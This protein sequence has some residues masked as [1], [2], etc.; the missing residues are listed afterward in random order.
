MKYTGLNL[1]T[2]I[3]ISVIAILSFS[4][5]LLSTDFKLI[6]KFFSLLLFLLP[7]LVYQIINWSDRFN[8][9][10]RDLYPWAFLMGFGILSN[11]ALIIN[12]IINSLTGEL[13]LIAIGA[14][15]NEEI[16][17]LLTVY[18]IIKFGYRGAYTKLGLIALGALVGTGFALTE[19]LYYTIS[20]NEPFYMVA[21]RM[22]FAPFFHATTGAIYALVLFK[23][24]KREYIFLALIFL[25][26]FHM[27]WNI[28]ALINSSVSFITLL[29]LLVTAVFISLF[30]FERERYAGLL[31]LSY[32]NELDLELFNESNGGNLSEI[33]EIRNYK[34]YI[35]SI[36]EDNLASNNSDKAN[37]LVEVTEPPL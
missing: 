24:K 25:I 20:S 16:L 32:L 23:S 28:S 37:E 11:S 36:Y 34:R 26:S 4:S 17:K 35:I 33:E 30:Y 12:E 15:L 19:D 9:G 13:T 10:Q 5:I 18:I 21:M 1:T 29:S 6:N 31:E 7:F 8:T 27:V 3:V 14:P 2:K 22:I